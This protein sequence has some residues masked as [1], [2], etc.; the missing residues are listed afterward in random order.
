MFPNWT[1]ILISRLILFSQINN[2][3]SV[4]ETLS[5]VARCPY[6]PHQNIT[7]LITTEGDYYIASMVDFSARD[8][9][10]YR[11]KG[12]PPSMLRTVQ[13]NSKWLSGK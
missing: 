11:F 6:S 8:P 5:G 2:I 10:V 1:L 9:A 7:A 12:H 13:Y 4:T 3:N